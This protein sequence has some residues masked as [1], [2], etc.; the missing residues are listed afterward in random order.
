MAPYSVIG[1]PVARP[2]GVDKVT[3][4]PTF[5]VNGVM[6]P[7]QEVPSLADLDAAIAKAGRR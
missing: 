6:L 2:D 1:Q 5:F 7:N 4:T 3:G